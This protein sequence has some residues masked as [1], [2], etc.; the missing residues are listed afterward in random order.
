MASLLGILLWFYVAERSERTAPPTTPDLSADV[1]V[2]APRDVGPSQPEA[3]PLVPEARTPVVTR[4]EPHLSGPATEA[5]NA[6]RESNDDAVV[7]AYLRHAAVFTEAGEFDLAIQAYDQA[8]DHDPDNFDFMLLRA[9][10]VE[11]RDTVKRRGLT[12][13]PAVIRESRTEYMPSSSES[14]RGR[15]SETSG[16]VSIRRATRAPEFP[17]ELVIGLR[18]RTVEPGAPYVVTVRLYNKG[19]RVI[20]VQAVEVLFRFDGGVEG[21]GA[22]YAPAVFRVNPRE[23]VLLWERQGV[24]QERQVPGGVDVTVHLIDGAQ[25]TK[26]LSW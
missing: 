18:P 7:A 1:A 4:E 20:G 13:G 5:E 26:K 10:V 16:G 24:W 14:D 12:G 17:G 22:R 23:T 19:N 9:Q 6:P 11:M 25:L 15:S 8:I 3:A 21:Q 2:D